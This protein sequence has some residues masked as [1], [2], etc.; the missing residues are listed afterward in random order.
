LENGSRNAF[1]KRSAGILIYAAT[2]GVSLS[3]CSAPK[4]R[5][6]FYV[7]LIVGAIMAVSAIP[8]L[9]AAVKDG[10]TLT[11]VEDIILD[12]LIGCFVFVGPAGLMLWHQLRRLDRYQQT[13]NDEKRNLTPRST[14]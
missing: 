10:R 6:I 13:I 7:A 5:T 3:Q 12:L 4:T 14:A 9:S 11:L 1:H 2:Q 8:L